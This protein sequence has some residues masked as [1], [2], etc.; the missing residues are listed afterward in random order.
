M[1][2]YK[3][4]YLASHTP[5]KVKETLLTLGVK[6]DFKLKPSWQNIPFVGGRNHKL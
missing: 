4:T 1:R 5:Y 3:V 6:T 2:P